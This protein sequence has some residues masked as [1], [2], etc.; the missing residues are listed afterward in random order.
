MGIKPHLTSMDLLWKLFKDVRSR[1]LR[2]FWTDLFS[3]IAS[4]F[5]T[6]GKFGLY[7]ANLT[8]FNLKKNTIK[9][10]ITNIRFGTMFC[11]GKL[12]WIPIFPCRL[13]REVFC[14]WECFMVIPN[15]PKWSVKSCFMNSVTTFWQS[16]RIC[17]EGFDKIAPILA[18]I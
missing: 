5:I 13:H 15:D 12:I 2:T 8:I 10:L 18:W 16:W 14:F 7:N 11:G 17:C 3:I 6:S 9:F 4:Y 1:V